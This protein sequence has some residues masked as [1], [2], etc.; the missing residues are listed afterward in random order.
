MSLKSL[1]TEIQR[2]ASEALERFDRSLTVMLIKIVPG[3]RGAPPEPCAGWACE[4]QIA[5]QRRK[6]FFIGT[7]DDAEAT[8]RALIDH[9]DQVERIKGVRPAAILIQ[10]QTPPDDCLLIAK[11]T[12]GVSTQQHV[13]RFHSMLRSV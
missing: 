3:R 10:Q 12:R 1:K 13:A 8:I 6:L 5:G 2:T 4:Y 9:E 11:A 7:E